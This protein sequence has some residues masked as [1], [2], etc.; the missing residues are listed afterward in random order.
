MIVA[1]TGVGINYSPEMP[2]FDVSRH[3]LGLG[4]VTTVVIPLGN[5]LVDKRGCVLETI[6][7]ADGDV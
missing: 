3:G 6:L 4:V 7:D 5:E 2:D 1:K